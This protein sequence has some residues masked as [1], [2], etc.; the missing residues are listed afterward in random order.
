[1][2]QRLLEEVCSAFASSGRAA[3]PSVRLSLCPLR[4]RRP[5]GEWARRRVGPSVAWA[6]RDRPPRIPGP[7]GERGGRPARAAGCALA[8]RE[9]RELGEEPGPAA[10][11][12]PLI[13]LLCCNFARA[14]RGAAPPRARPAPLPRES[15]RSRPGRAVETPRAAPPPGSETSASRGL[16]GSCVP[17]GRRLRAGHQ[18]SPPTGKCAAAKGGREGERP[19]SGRRPA[20]PEPW[21]PDKD[22]LEV[23]EAHFIFPQRGLAKGRKV[24]EHTCVSLAGRGVCLRGSRRGPRLLPGK[25]VPPGEAGRDPRPRSGRMPEAGIPPTVEV[26]ARGWGSCRWPGSPPASRLRAIPAGVLAG[27]CGPT[28]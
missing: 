8:G 18:R 3:R 26:P 15:L 28:R 9:R 1:M 25:L 7:G 20:S 5:R 10:A 2:T 19:E 16:L 23:A 21:P 17:E 22:V 4:A 11:A 13:G 24:A 27:W 6:R 12:L 14:L